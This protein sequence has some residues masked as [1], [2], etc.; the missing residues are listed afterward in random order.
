V[1]QQFL[2]PIA[3]MPLAERRQVRFVLCDIDGTLTFECRLPACAYSALEELQR[4]R[5][6][7]IPVTGRP[8]G[9]CD[10]IARMWPVD[11]VVGENGAFTFRYD[12]A[13]R[14]MERQ[15]WNDDARRGEERRRLDEIARTVLREIPGAAVAA[16]QGFRHTDLA[17]DYCEDT[18]PLGP[19]DVA[20][21]VAVFEAAGATA[22]VSSIHVNGWFGAHD[23]RKM[24]ERLLQ[25]VFAH[26]IRADPRPVVFVGD[27]PNDAPLFAGL[28]NSVGVANVMAFAENLDPPPAWVTTRPGGHGF[29]E[30]A[31]ALLSAR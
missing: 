9:W 6:V 10:H 11:A 5:L 12:G 14:R 25:T 29:A 22:K 20:R 1:A 19:E 30:L 26:N 13:R 3:E 7:V 18:G 8:A 15:Y 2:R 24:V 21:I 31:W 16:D 27:S 4:A 28:P 23:K 17:I